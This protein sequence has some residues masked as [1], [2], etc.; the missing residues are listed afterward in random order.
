VKN[1]SIGVIGPGNHFKNRIEPVLRKNKLFKI[2]GFLKKKKI[3]KKNYFSENEFFNQKFDFVYISCPNQLH[4]KYII[5]SLKAGYHVICE[6]PFIMNSKKLRKIISLSERY[7]K[8]IVECFMYAYHPVFL[9]IKKLLKNKR[10][11]PVDYVISNFKFPS[12]NKNN[13]RYLKKLGNGF[14]YDAAVYPISLE[15]YLFQ[16]KGKPRISQRIFKDKNNVDSKG[17]ICIEN[18]FVKRFYFWGEG[19]NYSNNLEIFFKKGSIFIDKFYSK[20]L[21]EQIFLKL[22]SSKNIYIKKFK[23]VD[24]FEIMLKNIK[25]NYKKANFL[26]RCRKLIIDQTLLLDLIKSS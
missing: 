24:H 16:F 20:K 21:N 26:K 9:Y 1:Q 6:K 14:F 4:E 7:N 5:K 10:L 23:N 17:Y 18:N 15:S 22:N 8:L 13:N 25:Q 12:L 19:Q 2:K 11:G 3:N